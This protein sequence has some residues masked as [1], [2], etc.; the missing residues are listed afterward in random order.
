MKNQKLQA[1]IEKQKKYDNTRQAKKMKKRE[2]D[3]NE[4]E[5]LQR[6]ENLAKK[7]KKGIIT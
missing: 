1:K 2:N 4:W 3:W 5:E 6:E 7:V